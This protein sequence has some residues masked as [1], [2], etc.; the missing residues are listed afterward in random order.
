MMGPYGVT[1]GALGPEIDLDQDGTPE[2]R[3][4]Y[5]SYEW[6]DIVS[7]EMGTQHSFEALNG[8]QFL[9]D[10]GAR[11]F[12]ALPKGAWIG[13]PMPPGAAWHSP[14]NLVTLYSWSV[15]SAYDRLQM[16]WVSVTNSTQA[17]FTPAGLPTYLAV[18]FAGQKGWRYGWVLL[19]ECA[20]VMP[21]VG[22]TLSDSLSGRATLLPGIA[23]ISLAGMGYQVQPEVGLRAGDPVVPLLCIE[24]QATEV[25]ITWEPPLAGFTLQRASRLEDWTDELA[26]AL[27]PV[28]RT[29]SPGAA[30]FRLA[31]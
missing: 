7:H 6:G 5:A 31:R 3:F 17:G 22:P 25:L 8:S 18:R 10:T 2:C 30:F 23:A 24:R 27:S 1:S 29:C 15:M 13:Y 21:W 12:M 20:W 19:S 4:R 14:S 16:T 28:R 11:S 26:G 9:W